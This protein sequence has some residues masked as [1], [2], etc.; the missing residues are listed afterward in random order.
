MPKRPRTPTRDL[1]YGSGSVV[2]RNGKWVARWFEGETRRA[3]TF[4]SKEEAEDFLR[5]R[6]RRRERGQSLPATHLTVADLIDDWLQR[7]RDD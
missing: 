7:S 6:R 3:K 5:D 2:P 4:P 1:A